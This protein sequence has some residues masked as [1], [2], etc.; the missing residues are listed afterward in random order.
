LK[1]STSTIQ[2]LIWLFAIGLAA[3]VISR[4]PLAD[5]GSSLL[6]L[7][8]TNWIVWIFINVIIIVLLTARW[9]SLTKA[10]GSSTNFFSLLRVRQA[11]Q[12]INFVT[13]GPQLGAEPLQVYWLWKRYYMSAHAALLT[14]GLDRFY[15]FWVNF[16]V[17]LLAVLVL[18][19]STTI[20]LIDWRV[21]A[22]MLVSLM[23]L[24]SLA[25][26]IV[27][28]KPIPIRNFL[29]R[30]TSP[31]QRHKRLSGL[32]SEWAKL[33]ELLKRV[34]TEKRN[35]LFI[36]FLLS[37]VSWVGMVLEFWLL[38]EFISVPIDV[39]TFIFL[40]VIVRL[41]FLL[42]FPGGIGT[43]EAALFWAFQSLTLPLSAAAALITL[44]RLRDL[45]ILVT[46]AV[47]LPGLQRP[48]PK[49]EA[50]RS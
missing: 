22:A 11:G 2:I 39:A 47:V 5:I 37:L 12:L 21:V 14:V 6:Q 20:A 15:E 29:K 31:W 38:L 7:S 40:F 27:L 26:W 35:T 43:V 34:I 19:S 44:M 13:P 33:Q 9:N 16:A 50:A 46:G 41:A 30:L 42:P 1:Q 36:A 45:V 8:L 10:I 28:R 48:N 23:L 25:A 18:F 24:M 49:N 32:H 17:L 4:L 3:L